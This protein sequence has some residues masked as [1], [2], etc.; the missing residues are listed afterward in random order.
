MTG[1]WPALWGL[2]SFLFHTI[3]T[4]AH[5]QPS[6]SI[7]WQVDFHRR[8]DGDEKHQAWGEHRLEKT[9]LDSKVIG[10]CLASQVFPAFRHSELLIFAYEDI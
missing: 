7:G 6:S 2:L 5:P 9:K 8:V 1:A 4:H 10:P 3:Q